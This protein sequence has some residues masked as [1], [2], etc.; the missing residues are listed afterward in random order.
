[1]V[2]NHERGDTEAY[3]DDRAYKWLVPRELV[4]LVVRL[5]LFDASLEV[6]ICRPL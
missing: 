2:S 3:L 4:F 1:M 6:L 5:F